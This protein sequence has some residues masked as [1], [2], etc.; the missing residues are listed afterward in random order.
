LAVVVVELLVVVEIFERTDN[1]FRLS[2]TPAEME[3][4][5]VTGVKPLGP[6]IGL[7]NLSRGLLLR[8]EFS[9]SSASSSVEFSSSTLLSE[10]SSLPNV[11]DWVSLSLT[12]NPELV[13]F[14]RNL[15]LDIAET[16]N[17]GIFDER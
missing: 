5:R 12:S 1:G 14:M 4:G 2:E 3:V 16:R 15:E 8:L 9:S 11:T 17:P 6:F 10:L 13:G 7:R